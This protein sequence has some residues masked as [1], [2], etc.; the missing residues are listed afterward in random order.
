M[1]KILL[2]S[3]FCF[4]L[5]ALLLLAGCAGGPHGTA[6]AGYDNNGNATVNA[7]LDVTTNVNVGVTGGY[8]VPSG[9]WSAGFL[10]TFKDAVPP[11]VAQQLADAGGVPTRNTADLIWQFP[12]VKSPADPAYQKAVVAAAGAGDFTVTP[13]K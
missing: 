5:S 2:L 6:G 3:A 4:L 8:N 1:K 11:D 12:D 9:N 7:G 10:I 13:L